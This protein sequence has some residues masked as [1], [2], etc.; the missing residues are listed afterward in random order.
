MAPA[1]DILFQ[2]RIIQFNCF[3]LIFK[4]LGR[5]SNCNVNVKFWLLNVFMV[6]FIEQVLDTILHVKRIKKI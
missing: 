5:L 4:S 2:M 3:T 6:I 1:G